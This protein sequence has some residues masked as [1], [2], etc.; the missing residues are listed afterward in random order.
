MELG[1]EKQSYNSRF[2]PAKGKQECLLG[3]GFS[4]QENGKV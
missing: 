3:L 1:S 4:C 2:L